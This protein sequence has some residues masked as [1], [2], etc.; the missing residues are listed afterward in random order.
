M[1]G[2]PT[3][4]DRRDGEA[5]AIQ[6]HVHL[7]GEHVQSRTAPAGRSS[8]WRRAWST[9]P[10][11]R[12][13]RSGS[14]T[15]SRRSASP[16]SGA[17]GR[18]HRGGEPFRDGYPATRRRASAGGWVLGSSPRT[19]AISLVVLLAAPALPC[20]AAN[21]E[22]PQPWGHFVVLGLDPRTRAASAGDLVLQSA[23]V[24]LPRSI[25]SR[26][27]SAATN[28]SGSFPVTASRIDI[29]VAG[30]QTTPASRH[31]NGA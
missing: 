15:G 31:G 23:R 25:P 4:F 1:N 2:I 29:L 22:P 17:G 5:V 14:A 20:A 6:G 13:S 26:S 18:A 27:S 30:F 12:R 28:A 3:H 9:T 19:T 11:S 16:W 24:G 21:L 7:F 8:S 10:G